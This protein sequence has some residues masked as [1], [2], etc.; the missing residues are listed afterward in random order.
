[1][2]AKAIV[3]ATIL[4]LVFARYALADPSPPIEDIAMDVGDTGAFVFPLFA[5]IAGVVGG[6][7]LII[8]LLRPFFHFF[9]ER[10]SLQ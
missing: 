8:N 3:F 9:E 10:E 6:L 5:E 4:L 2:K 1:M 7:V